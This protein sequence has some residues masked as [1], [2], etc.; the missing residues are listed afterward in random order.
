MR[1]AGTGVTIS[2][3]GK[4]RSARDVEAA[5]RTLANLGCCYLALFDTATAQQYA[6]E[7]GRLLRQHGADTEVLRTRWALGRA[8]LRRGDSDEGVAWLTTVASDFRARGVV[9]LAAEVELDII[10]E[11]LAH[12]R[13]AEAAEMA[14]S[15]AEFFIAA[16]TPVNAANAVGYL[17]TAAREMRATPEVV[18]RVRHVVLHH[19]QQITAW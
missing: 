10:A 5:A 9:S 14:H 7:A 13:F 2:L 12:A 19:E 6:E 3:H 8:Y 11:L 15:L 4:R 16:G 1:Q 17:A 18:A